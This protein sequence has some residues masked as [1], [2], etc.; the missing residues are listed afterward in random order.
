MIQTFL[1]IAPTG[2]L[3][4]LILSLLVIGVMIPFRL[5][6]FPDLTA[7]GSYPLGG[8]LCASLIV[9]GTSPALSLIIASICAG[10]VGIGTALIHIRYKVNTLLAGIILST[11]V[12]SVN[13]RAMGKPNIAL[14]NHSTLFDDLSSGLSSQLIA[15]LIINILIIGFL[16][17][18]L[19]TEKGL[20]FR[21]VGL[22]PQFAKKQG[23]NLNSNI[24]SGLFIGN[25]TCG[26]AG[27]LLVQIQGY[28]DI[29]IGVGIVIHALAAMM[30]GEKIIGTNTIP[31]LVIAPFIG[32]LIY[33]Q[34]QGFAL[35][36]GL[37]PSD[38]KFITGAIVLGIIALK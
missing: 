2:F 11:M 14:F 9:S 23:I 8:A 32:S 3:Q 16:F 25:A 19:N 33:Q 22:N 12:Y 18:F 37:A 13:L 36:A 27:A 10:I 35:A 4:G 1:E 21:A 5:L 28:A 31:R 20:C 34:I 38:L 29:G 15:L 6:D 24:I 26:L 30:I 17:L 7:E